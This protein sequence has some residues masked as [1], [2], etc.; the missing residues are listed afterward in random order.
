M[1]ACAAAQATDAPTFSPERLSADVKTLS[2]D[3][4][5]GRGP[6]T[7]AET[8]TI[9]YVVAQMKAAGLQPGG[10][11]KDGKRSWT[12][13]VPL[14]RSEIVGAPKLTL[15][16]G[17]KHEA[18]TQGEQ[19]AVRAPMDGSTSVAIADAPLVFVGYGVEAPERH[20]DDF[21][22]VD[23]HG[24]IAVVLIN[25]PDF[26]TG[27][28]DFG[29]KAMTYYGRWTYKYEEAAR[30]G[31]LGVLIVHETAP[32]SY[33]W[34]TVK[35]SNTNTMFDI[36]RD[37]PSAMHPQLEAWIQRDLAVAMF[38]H[39]GL[40]FDALKKQAQTRAFKPVT[41]KGESLS[42]SF[43][44]DK[45]VITS[46]NIVGRI[47]GSKHP[48]QTVIYSAHWDHLGVGQPD[49]KG[50]RIY[51]GAVDNAT[52]TAALIELGRA[53]AHA[54]RP[55][56][57]VVF[58]NVTAEEKGLLGSEY[59]AANPLY[60]LA[61]TAGVLNMDALDPHGPARNFTI[62]GSAKLGLLDDLIADA[63]QYGMSYTADPKPEAGHFFRS[64]HFSFAKRGVPAISFGSG[65]DWV[66]GGLKAGK[67]AEDEYVVKH[68][69]QPSDEWQASWSFTGMARDLQLLYAVGSQ[70]ANSGQWP[71]WSK[72]SEFRGIRDASAA[73]RK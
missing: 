23:L 60:P 33:G 42:A 12:Q 67:A 46:H 10:D 32:A 66:N 15:A 58:L 19:I 31:A 30:K 16:L 59:Y 40:D 41:L 7:P 9:D 71:D 29:G 47:E 69:H 64:D 44:V 22:G 34:A 61:T 43:K 70:L 72:D 73:E 17:D 63:K 2:S 20:W 68:Y 65:N 48:E 51:N 27:V 45:S 18:L 13:A 55:E 21:K 62:S 53:F 26:E 36:V 52:G 3:A 6:A 39:A 5:E 50:D 11:L 24:K 38:K 8:K 54:P 37:Q 49:A 56:R 1:S 4:F 35:N 25:D 57:S 14:L 28:G